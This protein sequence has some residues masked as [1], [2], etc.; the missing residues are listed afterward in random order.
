MS[1]E[2]KIMQL[3]KMLGDKKEKQEQKTQFQKPTKP[4]YILEWEK[5]GLT[6][7][8]N[9]FGVVLKRQVEY[10]LNFKHG[11]YE[12]G[13]FFDAIEKWE[14]SNVNHPFSLSFDEDILFFDTETTGLKG[15]GTHIFLIGVIEVSNDKFILTQYVLADPENETAFL[16]ESK[17]WQR[18]K[19]IVTYNGK[20]FDWPQLETRWTLHQRHLPKLKEHRQIDLLHSSK[21]IW[22]NNLE[23]MKLSS[24]EEEK[25][26]FKR[27]GDIPGFL[28]PI[29]YADAIKSGNAETLMKVLVH[30]E[31]D[32]LS[33]ITLYIHS[34]NILLENKI[35][36]AA[37]TI[38]NVGKWYKDLKQKDESE[39]FLRSVTNN[40]NEEDSGLANYYLGFELKKNAQY[41]DA[42]ISFEKSIPYIE[43]KKKIKA[44]EQLAM[45]HEHQFKSF[46]KALDYTIQGIHLIEK[47]NAYTNEQKIKLLQS[48]EKR[49]QRIENKGNIIEN[50]NGK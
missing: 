13:G 35:E 18:S 33:L 45:I 32:L 47:T 30:N 11:H 31:W 41:K 24:V 23:K 10:P 21:R 27:I 15:V 4:T 20:S 48:W 19:T 29:I 12:L 42:V 39:L 9:D 5:S 3:K 28:A 22:K 38:T 8:E 44:F 34:T 36:E 25:L 40:F 7:I 50:P 14:S 43:V 1:Y 49:Y 2:N 17:F 26:G 16:F 37:T 46:N 6:S